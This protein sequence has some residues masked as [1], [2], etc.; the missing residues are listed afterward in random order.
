MVLDR[1][2]E[3]KISG[4]LFDFLGYLT[5]LPKEDEF[6]IGGSQDVSVVLEHLKEWAEKR[7]LN[8]EDADVKNWDC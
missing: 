2:M 4:A 7:G 5:T 8:I 3:E 6:K 1:F